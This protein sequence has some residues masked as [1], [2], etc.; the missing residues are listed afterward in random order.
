MALTPPVPPRLPPW[1]FSVLAVI[2]AAGLGRLL[3]PWAGAESAYLLFAIAVVI[4]L[5]QLS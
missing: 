3:A 1:A 2:A 4:S 5:L